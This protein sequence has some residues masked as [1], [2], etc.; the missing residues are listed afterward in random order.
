M[1]KGLTLSILADQRVSDM[2]CNDFCA[3]APAQNRAPGQHAPLTPF[4][5]ALKITPHLADDQGGWER[6]VE[7]YE[8]KPSRDPVNER[9][10]YPP[11]AWEGGL[12]PLP[13]LRNLI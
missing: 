6:L 3:E 1:Q 9:I 2:P 12:Y 13:H 8:A 10:I 4:S 11:V 5:S 7:L